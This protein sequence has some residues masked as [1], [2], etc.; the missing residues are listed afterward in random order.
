MDMSHNAGPI[1]EVFE[2]IWPMDWRRGR[3]GGDRTGVSESDPDSVIDGENSEMD[4]S[5]SSQAF[6]IWI[7]IQ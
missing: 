1:L 4:S 7:R 2:W 3:L 6:L 5:D